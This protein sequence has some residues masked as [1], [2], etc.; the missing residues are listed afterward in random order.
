VISE[1]GTLTVDPDE[2]ALALLTVSA[3]ST[4]NSEKSGSTI[5]MVT[6]SPVVIGPQRGGYTETIAQGAQI[7][8]MAQSVGYADNVVD[9]ELSGATKAGTSFSDSVRVLTVDV[10]EPVGTMLTLRAALKESETDA[11]N[12]DGSRKRGALELRVVPAVSSV[13]VNEPEGGRNVVKEKTLSLSAKVNGV[14]SNEVIFTISPQSASMAA[15]MRGV[16]YVPRSETAATVKVRAT[17]KVDETKYGEI[18]INILDAPQVTSV[19]VSPATPSVGQGGTQVFTATVVGVGNVSQQVKWSITGGTGT[20]AIANKPGNIGAYTQYGATLSVASNQVIASGSITVTA[21]AKDKDGDGVEVTGSTTVTVTAPVATVTSVTV[22]PAKAN[23]P[24]G[25][26]GSPFTQ[27]VTGTNGPAQEVTWSLTGSTNGSS[28][29]AASG[30]IT[31]GAGE[32]NTTLTVKATSTLDTSK[33]GTATITVRANDWTEFSSVTSSSAT[34]GPY[35][36]YTTSY[37]T[38][39]YADNSSDKWY[40]FSGDSGN[41]RSK[42]LSLWYRTTTSAS[43]LSVIYD[44]AGG[45][46]ND[47]PVFIAVGVNGLMAK[48]S[49]TM[50]TSTSASTAWTQITAANGKFAAS[51]TIKTVFYGGGVFI[52]GSTIG[53]I[54]RSTDGGANWANP[55]TNPFSANYTIRSIVF[56]GNSTFYMVADGNAVGNNVKLARSTD[57]GDN[58]TEL[59]SL[60]AVFGTGSAKVAFG[61]GKI[62]VAGSSDSGFKVVV[63][64]DN[65]VTW[66]AAVPGCFVP[67]VF[68]SSIGTIIY[69]GARFI[70]IG[71]DLVNS[72]STDGQNWTRLIFGAASGANLIGNI[73]YDG[74]NYVGRSQAKIFKI[75]SLF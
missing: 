56:D 29:D 24:K 10:D 2:S 45:T 38:F 47:A 35:A 52:A 20:T 54:S 40:I 66:T 61:G 13:S 57:N 17:S 68:S 42:N 46:Y 59:P 25:Y 73:K 65:G 27:T 18:D 30:A 43:K 51:E 41:I 21:T 23:M 31:I 72:Y 63:S 28:I 22:S 14:N 60:Q 32:T 4:A 33:Y 70:I 39:A 71:G 44:I 69:D 62:V 49:G 15:S 8:F 34:T 11:L 16:L 53:T 74:A 64:S 12:T 55:T 7:T 36:T 50:I 1:N 6:H 48:A 58:W 67:D 75:S 3:T 5:A 37:R 19:T 26:T 9:W